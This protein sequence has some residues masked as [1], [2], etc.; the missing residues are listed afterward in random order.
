M[1]AFSTKR[2]RLP[3]QHLFAYLF[4]VLS[5]TSPVM[6][7]LQLSPCWLHSWVTRNWSIRTAHHAV[8]CGL[9][10]QQGSWLYKLSGGA[11]GQSAVTLWNNCMEPM[12]NL[13]LHSE[14]IVWSQWPICSH[15]RAETVVQ[16]QFILLCLCITR[17]AMCEVCYVWEYT[18]TPPCMCRCMHIWNAIQRNAVVCVHVQQLV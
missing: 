12:A 9:P 13:L 17:L 5:C 8:S 3:V 1:G 4:S 16:I 2:S 7:S 6:T 15:M 10:R 14:T 18:H 11:N